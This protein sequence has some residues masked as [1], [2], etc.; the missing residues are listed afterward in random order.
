M[1]LQFCR[2]ICEIQSTVKFHKKPSRGNRG[3]TDRQ[4]KTTLIIALP[5]FTKAPKN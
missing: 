1:K 5:N 3:Q 4:E 2:Q